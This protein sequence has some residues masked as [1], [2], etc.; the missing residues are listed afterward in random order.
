MMKKPLDVLLAFAEECDD[1]ACGSIPVRLGTDLV[2]DGA[3]DAAVALQKFRVVWV[4]RV[5]VISRVLS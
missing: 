3:E 2:S 4:A 1:E 5:E